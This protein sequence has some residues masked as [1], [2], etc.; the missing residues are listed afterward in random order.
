MSFRILG[1]D[2]TPYRALHA[3]SDTDL[4]KCGVRR[5]VASAKPEA[6]CRISLDDANVGEEVLLVSCEHQPAH[7]PYQQQGPIFVRDNV[8]Q[9]D[10]VDMIPPALAVRPLSLRGYDAQH[11]MVHGELIEGRDA[12]RGD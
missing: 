5:A 6:P 8:S 10:G 2:P 7:T 12:P 1:L 9:F 4:A 11:M 3:L